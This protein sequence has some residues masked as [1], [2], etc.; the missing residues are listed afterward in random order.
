M[1]RKQT[2]MHVSRGITAIIGKWAEF[3]Q[4]GDFE[5]K[6]A[7]WRQTRLVYVMRKRYSRKQMAAAAWN[8]IYH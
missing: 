4:E 1:P 8:N 2:R 6:E 7:S 5:Q 3:I